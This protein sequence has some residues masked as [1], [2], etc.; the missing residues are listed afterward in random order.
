MRRASSSGCRGPTFGISHARV[1]FRQIVAPSLLVD[2]DEW[3]V[4]GAPLAFTI[5]L[6][7]DSNHPAVKSHSLALD[8]DTSSVAHR[9][10]M[11][12]NGYDIGIR[13]LLRCRSRRRERFR[14]V[15]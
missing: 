9:A 4:P 2:H 12:S 6:A 13:K 7:A 15:M 5:S 8:L 10:F 3:S 1:L 11:V 14:R